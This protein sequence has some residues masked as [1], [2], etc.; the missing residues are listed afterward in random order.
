MHGRER[1]FVAGVH[2]LEHIERFRAAHFADD[3][4]VR[5]HTQRIPHEIALG[6]LPT[7]FRRW[8]PGLQR[9]PV[10]LLETQ[11]QRILD[12]DDALRR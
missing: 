10:P 4:P 8:W 7:P 9:D 11:L 3:D 5:A 6:N 12:R 2:G 1:A